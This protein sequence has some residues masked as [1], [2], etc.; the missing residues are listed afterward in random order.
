MRT[1]SAAQSSLLLALVAGRYVAEGAKHRMIVRKYKTDHK[2]DWW[3]DGRAEPYRVKFSKFGL[4]SAYFFGKSGTLISFKD[5]DKTFKFSSDIG[6]RMLHAVGK[7][8]DEQEPSSGDRHP[9]FSCPDCEDTWNKL[10]SVG[11]EDVCALHQYPRHDFDAN[12]L[13]SVRRMCTAFGAACETS[14]PDTCEGKCVP[15]EGEPAHTA[16]NA[17]PSPDM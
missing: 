4:R 15:E 12:A 1:P 5:D 10:C 2:I 16:L 14:A 3:D 11:L 6:S 13:D 8:E 17:S 9:P 7:G